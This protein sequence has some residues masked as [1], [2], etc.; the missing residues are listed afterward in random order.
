[1]RSSDSGTTSISRWLAR[2]RFSNWPPNSGRYPGGSWTRPSSNSARA[3][4]TKLPMSRPRT[5]PSTI[6]SR[7]PF[8]WLISAGPSTSS[9]LASW[10]SGTRSP[11]G[12][13]TSS[14]AMVCVFCRAASGNRT[15]S[16]KRRWPSKTSVA[17]TPPT[18][19]TVCITSAELMP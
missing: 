15:A 11:P 17:T 14:D 18:A 6:R 19:S 10:P 7:E 13:L 3:S 5:F 4:A 12:A 8:S 16:A 9:T 1:M 2:S